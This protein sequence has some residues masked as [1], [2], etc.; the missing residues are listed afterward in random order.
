MGLRT[1]FGI[2]SEGT[3]VPYG[4][5][6]DA[7]RKN[8]G[9]QDLRGSPGVAAN[10]P[11]TAGSDALRRLL[12]AVAQPGFPLFTLGCDL[13]THEE[14]SAPLTRRRVAGGYVQ[15]AA[16]EYAR[17]TPETYSA[18]ARAIVRAVRPTASKKWWGLEFILKGVAFK[19]DPSSSEVYP[20]VWIW[21]FSSAANLAE[22]VLSREGLINAIGNALASQSALEKLRG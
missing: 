13:G 5:I 8:H 17:T 21:F 3:T 19:F 18:F 4:P 22:A 11:E 9:F 2:D 15:I 6:S 14:P 10:I 20:T 1:R 12:V 16:V 7:I